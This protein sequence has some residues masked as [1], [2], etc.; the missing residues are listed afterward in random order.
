MFASYKTCLFQPLKNLFYNPLVGS[1]RAC[2]CPRPPPQ[3]SKGSS[4]QNA[5]TNAATTASRPAPA[6]T[7]LAAAPVATLKGA[8]LVKLPTEGAEAFPLPPVEL[9]PVLA[10][11]FNVLSTIVAVEVALTK[12]VELVEL[13]AVV[14]ATV[15]ED[16]RVEGEEVEEEKE[17]EE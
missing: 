11:V 12:I 16:D 4:Y 14:L 1:R 13:N 6:A 2:Y 8:E 3:P 7:G 10:A 15:A 17:D 9:A 5:A